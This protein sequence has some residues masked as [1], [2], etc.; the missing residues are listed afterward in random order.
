MRIVNAKTFQMDVIGVRCR[1]FTITW[2]NEITKHI[3]E[4]TQTLEEHLKRNAIFGMPSTIN[5]MAE[6]DKKRACR[7]RQT[8]RQIK[9]CFTCMI[10]ERERKINE[11]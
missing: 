5:T 2:T 9:T 6:E 3:T 7:K 4:N 11:V 10:T 8:Q 1:M